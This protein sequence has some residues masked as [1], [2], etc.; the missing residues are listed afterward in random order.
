MEALSRELDFPYRRNGAL[1]LCFEEAGLPHL[2][3]LLHRGQ[4]N[5][6]EGLE[7][8]RGEQLRALEP[9]LSEKAVAALYAP[10][11]AIICPFGM[12]IALAENAAHNGVTLPLRH[13]GGAH[14][15][16]SGG[17]YP[18]NQPGDHGDPGRNQRRRRVGRCAP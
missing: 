13:P 1:V 7:I 16:D 17:L 12:T 6:V 4:V 10:S 8:A 2:E 3:E 11:S 18:G 15:P 14:P 5:G 9:A